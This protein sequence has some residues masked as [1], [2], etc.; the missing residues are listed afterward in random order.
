MSY[1]TK[2]RALAETFLKDAELLTDDRAHELAQIIQDAIEGYIDV[3][4]LPKGPK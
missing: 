4:G 1:D 2:C 3:E